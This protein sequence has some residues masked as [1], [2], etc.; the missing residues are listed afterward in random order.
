MVLWQVLILLKEIGFPR[1]HGKGSVTLRLNYEIL[2]ILCALSSSVG[3]R[4]GI[5]LAPLLGC[6]ES[7]AR[8]HCDLALFLHFVLVRGKPF[9]R[10]PSYFLR[11]SR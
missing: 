10:I 6:A 5:F 11:S 1:A 7:L 3:S 4:M 9:C 2:N 8:S